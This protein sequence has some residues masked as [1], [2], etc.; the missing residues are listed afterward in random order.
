MQRKSDFQPTKEMQTRHTRVTLCASVLSVKFLHTGRRSFE[1]T[2][3]RK[4]SA[5]KCISKMFVRFPPNVT[6][7]RSE[8]LR[9]P[10]SRCGF[11]RRGAS[12]CFSYV[13]LNQYSGV[14]K[15]R[16]VTYLIKSSRVP[17]P[18][19]L[20]IESYRFPKLWYSHRCF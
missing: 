13:R 8:K 6:E 12:R 7:F 9:V 19:L 2:V 17:P 16:V 20:S 15:Q 14:P 10:I 4:S 3:R 18:V 1:N 5:P 11:P